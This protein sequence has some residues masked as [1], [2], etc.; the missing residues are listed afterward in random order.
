MFDYCRFRWK[1]WRNERMRRAADGEYERKLRELRARKAPES[2]IDE[3]S[4]GAM[5]DDYE[6]DDEVHELHTDY[7]L[8]Q[9]RRLMLE[10]PDWKDEERWTQGIVTGRRHLTKKGISE[11]RAAIRSERKAAR[12]TLLMWVPGIT[13]ILGLIV[14]LV[15]ILAGKK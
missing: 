8:A 4:S 12:E 11:L 7:L 10:R 2:E 5:T 3:L 1:L 13:G 6:L 15:A 14:A 9:S